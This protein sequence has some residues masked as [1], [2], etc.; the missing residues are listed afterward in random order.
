MDKII[1]FNS[2]EY[3]FHKK[4]N[5]AIVLVSIDENNNTVFE[6]N[7]LSRL[8]FEEALL[9]EPQFDK[10]IKTISEEYNVTIEAVQKDLNSF[11]QDLIDVGIWLVS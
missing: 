3:L 11:S 10:L 5:G 7:G 8:F 1:K 4:G 6:I 2:N 9:A